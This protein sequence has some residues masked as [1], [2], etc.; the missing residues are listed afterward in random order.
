MS[1]LEP[2]F[3]K[4]FIYPFG[5]SFLE[6]FLLHV[7]AR[8]APKMLQKSTFLLL[9]GA[10]VLEVVFKSIFGRRYV[11]KPSKNIVKTMVFKLFRFLEILRK[12]LKNQPKMKPEIMTFYKKHPSETI[13]FF[14]YF[15]FGFLLGFS[16]I[17]GL[18]FAHIFPNK[19][20]FVRFGAS[21]ATKK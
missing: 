2:F 15:L 14:L 12:V 7:D 21:D 5:V 18:H 8:R 4:Y 17:V 13:L 16:S 11:P 9:S 1:V 6:R 10:F 20:T 3:F 19:S